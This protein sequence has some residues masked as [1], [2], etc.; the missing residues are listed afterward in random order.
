MK[1]IVNQ[2]NFGPGR[3]GT[4][5]FFQTTGDCTI[6]FAA[7][8][9]DPPEMIP[10]FLEKWEQGAKVVWGRKK[11]DEEKGLIKLFR[12]A[13]YSMV[14][15]FSTEKQF[16]NVTG[17][18]LCDKEVVDLIRWVEPESD[19]AD[20]NIVRVNPPARKADPSMFDIPGSWKAG[21]RIAHEIIDCYDDAVR[22]M[23]DAV[24]LTHRVEATKL[25]VRKV[26]REERDRAEEALNRFFESCA[27]KTLSF[28][29]NAAM[30][31]HA[32]TLARY[33]YQQKHHIFEIESHFL[34]LN[35]IA[36]A[37]NPFELFLDYGNRIR[38]QSPAAQTILIQLANGSLGYLPTETAEQGSHYSAYVS[39]GI[40]GH[41]GGDL[42][43][44]ETLDAFQ[45]LFED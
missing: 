28:Y 41:E 40:T 25:P 15:M 20:P 5:G 37:T 38:A 8:L 21:R 12:K 34:R 31:V 17:F 7:D 18:G 32:G 1:L 44:R 3:S 36:F 27:G 14:Q 6:S 43:V 9:Q 42:L 22:E 13:Y 45:Q 30:H 33:D 10:E 35:D 23:R 4:H 16:A 29:D 39:S 26:T 2:R 24:C 11:G 19:L